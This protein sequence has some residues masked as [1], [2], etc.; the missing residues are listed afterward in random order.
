MLNVLILEDDMIL[1]RAWVDLLT[2]RGHDVVHAASTREALAYVEARDFDVVISDLFIRGS[3]G[4]PMSEG[5]LTLISKVGGRLGTEKRP[6]TIAVTGS[7][8]RFF[9]IQ[10]L[11]ISQSLGADV[12]LRKPVDPATLILHVEDRWVEPEDGATGS[13]DESTPSSGS[14]EN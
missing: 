3:A 9:A 13:D 7:D 5:G 4:Q 10:P 1:A 14:P 11:D 8:G 2:E 6:K 12:A